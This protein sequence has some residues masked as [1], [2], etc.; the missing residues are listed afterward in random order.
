MTF[1][2][3][4]LDRSMIEDEI[5]SLIDLL[6]DAVDNGASVGFLSPLEDK[7]AEL[8]WQET[9][10]IVLQEN[11]LLLAAYDHGKIVGCA[12]LDLIKKPS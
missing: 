2:I 10:A 1:L 11:R 7:E 6:R 8:F 5:E 12:Q 4:K 3:K 9:S